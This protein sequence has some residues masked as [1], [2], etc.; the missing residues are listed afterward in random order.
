VLLIDE[1]DKADLQLPNELLHLFEEG[2]FTIE[3][4]RREGGDTSKE[5]VKTC[6]DRPV[7][8]HGGQVR[9]HE[10]PIVVMTSN[11]ERDFPP[12]FH[13]RCL[14]IDMPRPTHTSLEQLV[15]R[16]FRSRDVKWDPSHDAL[17]DIWIRDFLIGGNNPDRAIDQLLNAVYLLTQTSADQLQEASVRQ[18]RQILQRR[19]S[20]SG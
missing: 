10:F 9:C 12:A 2:Q 8:I 18:L 20:E 5:T 14:R 16:H 3:E 4:L 1:I 17:L 7:T 13:R 11:R 15:K 19:L 6:D